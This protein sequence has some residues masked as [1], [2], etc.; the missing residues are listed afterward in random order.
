M[1]V[2]SLK[3]L[4]TLSEWY[5][6]TMK[7]LLADGLCHFTKDDVPGVKYVTA[8]SLSCSIGFMEKDQNRFDRWLEFSVRYRL[9]RKC[10]YSKCIRNY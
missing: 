6:K 10:C 8:K 4:S 1:S 7:N 5:D 2:N 9:R 3:L